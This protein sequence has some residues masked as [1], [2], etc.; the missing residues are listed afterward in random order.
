MTSI[1]PDGLWRTLGSKVAYNQNVRWTLAA[2]AE[3]TTAKSE[4]FTEGASF[5]VTSTVI[6]RNPRARAK[7]TCIPGR[8]RWY[9]NY[10]LSY[11]DP[12]AMM[13]ERGTHVL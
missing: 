1:D 4:I 6:E 2:C 13:A 3:T 9:I 5:S 11:R 8:L 12:V 7:G 10:R